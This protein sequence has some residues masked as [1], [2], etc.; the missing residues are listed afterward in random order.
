MA[1]RM[2]DSQKNLPFVSTNMFWKTPSNRGFLQ[3]L[4]TCNLFEKSCNFPKRLVC[5]M[6]AIFASNKCGV[7]K[8]MGWK[9]RG[10]WCGET[11]IQCLI[12]K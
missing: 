6:I 4:F 1:F 9:K 10:E 2:G 5:D 11:L 8:K 3:F 7:W 12:N